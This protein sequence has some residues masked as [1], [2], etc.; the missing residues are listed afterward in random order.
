MKCKG[1]PVKLPA[2][3]IAVLAVA[4]I[5]ICEQPVRAQTVPAISNVC[6]NGAVQFQSSAMLTFTTGSSIAIA[7][8]A[9][10]VQ[11]TGTTL[12]GS[13]FATTST[14]A[15]D[16]TVTGTSTNQNVSAPLTGNMIYTAVIQVST[17]RFYRITTQ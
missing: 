10:A 17:L 14:T 4:G 12:L 1:C 8:S 3:I 15:N 11:L 5:L 16:L 9:I 13:T 7:S 6:P 2:F